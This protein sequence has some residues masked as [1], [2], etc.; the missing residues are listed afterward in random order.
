MMQIVCKGFDT[1][2]TILHVYGE[3][4]LSSVLKDMKNIIINSEPA[5]L[6]CMP[7]ESTVKKCTQLWVLKLK[8]LSGTF[9]SCL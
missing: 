1:S 4:N 6:S 8:K 9:K 7:S 3:Q 5:Y 2:S